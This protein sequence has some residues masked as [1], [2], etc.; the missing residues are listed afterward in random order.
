VAICLHLS[1]NMAW[2]VLLETLVVLGLQVDG[3]GCLGVSRSLSHLGNGRI[4]VGEPMAL[5]SRSSPKL[6]KTED[7]AAT[8]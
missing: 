5:Y 3:A 1:A 4:F 7:P 8:M 6:A 2:A